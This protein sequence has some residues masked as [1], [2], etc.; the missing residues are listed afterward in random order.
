MDN[1]ASILS[2][3]PQILNRLESQRQNYVAQHANDIHKDALINPDEYS[4]PFKDYLKSNSKILNPTALGVGIGAG[5]AIPATRGGT[6]G[7]S[8]LRDKLLG[9]IGNKFPNSNIAQYLQGKN[10]GSIYKGKNA[11]MLSKMQG[12]MLMP[13]RIAGSVPDVMAKTDFSSLPG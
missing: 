12:Q 11:A 9:N 1:I 3:D 10:P 7:A 4:Q 2:K 8:F 13:N 5:T 6:Y